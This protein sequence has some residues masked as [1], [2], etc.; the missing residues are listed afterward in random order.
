MKRIPVICLCALLSLCGL[1]FGATKPAEKG[2]SEFA[3]SGT[4]VH[5]NG[6][7]AAWNADGQIAFPIT[8]TG[9]LIVGPKLHLEA[10][11]A[12]DAAGA[13]VELNLTGSS[14]T[15][16]YIGANGLYD[17]KEAAGSERY[18]ADAVAGFKLRVKG[19]SGI[20]LFASRTVAGRGKSAAQ[21][22]GNVGIFV[23]F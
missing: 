9:A 10:D 14:A 3:I 6:G 16:P 13:V 19:S 2:K 5:V 17:L 8:K 23:A 7:P 15:G 4:Y 21:T 12:R 22:T 20:K 11:H 1:A 18:T